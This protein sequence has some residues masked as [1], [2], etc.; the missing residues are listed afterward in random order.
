MCSTTLKAAEAEK[1]GDS[2]ISTIAYKKMRQGE[3]ENKKRCC[4]A[5]GG[6]IPI[7]LCSP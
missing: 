7:P 5:L 2:Y 6:S 4:A 3:R 1:E